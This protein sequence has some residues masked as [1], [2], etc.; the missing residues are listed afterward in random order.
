MAP[1]SL[2]TKLVLAITGMVFVLVAAFSFIYV[3]KVIRQRTTQAYHTA[4]FIAKEILE[5]AG[6]VTH[7][8]P[9]SLGIDPNDPKSLE[10]VINDRLQHDPG[11]IS[12]FN[13]IIGF[14]DIVYDAAIA[15][16]HEHAIVNTNQ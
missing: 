10:R 3:S 4:D 2:K 7:V 16:N 11:L 1:V 9:A 5:R 12:L 8:D 6:D 14:S 13:A 15:D